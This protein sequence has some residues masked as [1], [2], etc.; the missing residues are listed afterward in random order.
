M[1]KSASRIC[2]GAV[3]AATLVTTVALHAQNERLR[4]AWN[5]PQKPFRV[6]GNTYWVGTRALGSVLV[7]SNAG[8]IL[9][10][11]ALPESVTQI[12]EHIREL[13][14][15][16]EDI[17]LI[18]NTH[19]HY[20]HAGGIAE[21]QR[22]SGA[23]V[24]A[25]AASAAVLKT[26]SAEADD[27]QYGLL[28]SFPPVSS[29]QIVRNGRTLSVGPLHVTAHMTPGH[30]A[31]GTSWSWRSCEGARCL[32]IVYADSLSPVSNDTFKY[33]TSP[34]LKQLEGSYTTLE[35]LPCDI[36]LTPHTGFSPVLENLAAREAGNSD[37]FVDDRACKS[38]VGA[39]RSNLL[40][41]LNDE[42][43]QSRER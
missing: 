20:D 28:D 19:D 42:R 14:F 21:L 31:G 37:A 6:F 13:G 8:H 29:V 17:K 33:T 34:L 24:A 2:S 10:D 4:A 35:N 22:V 5:R 1:M 43:N 36:L 12:R 3:L 26:G 9:I 16:V 39:M 18:L 40:K 25:S 41:R 15:E 11:A 27:P 38:Y 32:N 30:T 7:T 23:Q